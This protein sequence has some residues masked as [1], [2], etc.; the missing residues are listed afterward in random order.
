MHLLPRSRSKTAFLLVMTCYQIALIRLLTDMIILGRSWTER[1]DSLTA[2]L[3]PMRDVNVMYFVSALLA[4]PVLESGMA[5][6]IIEALRRLRCNVIFQVLVPVSVMCL[7]HSI[8]YF[9]SGLLMAPLFL[10]NVVTY[11]YWR[12]LSFWAG[13][14]MM[15]GVHALYNVCAVLHTLAFHAAT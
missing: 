4:A 5:I 14:S 10:I 1:S 12:R 15:V 9:L 13:V 3:R 8:P 7:V 2:G 11:L 6:A